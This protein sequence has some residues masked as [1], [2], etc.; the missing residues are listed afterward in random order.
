MPI[1]RAVALAAAFSIGLCALGFA[2]VP[3]RAQ[4]GAPIALHVDASRAVQG[5]L[6]MHETIP[7]AA[8]PLTLSYPRWIPGEHSPS[9]PI[10]NLAGIVIRGGGQTIPWT[11]D[12]VDLY[13]FH[14]TVPSGVSALEVDFLYLGANG[15]NYSS[16]RQATP[17]LLSLTWNKV[18][19]TPQVADY[20]TQTIAPS[21]TLPGPDWKYATALE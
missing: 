4:G 18:I 2:D 8:G 3:A 16:A 12:P 6:A 20:A 21:L 19:L 1:S 10:S 7:V 13:A 14:L 5:L 9:G 17:N 15:G 11:R